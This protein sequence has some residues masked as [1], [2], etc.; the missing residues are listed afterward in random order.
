METHLVP[1]LTRPPK[2]N[3]HNTEHLKSSAE[4]TGPAKS[5]QSI[6]VPDTELKKSS[7]AYNKTT[8][9]KDFLLTSPGVKIPSYFKK[10]YAL[11]FRLCPK[12]QLYGTQAL[13]ATYPI[14]SSDIFPTNSSL[15][16]SAHTKS[17]SEASFLQC[18]IV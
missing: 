11:C 13:A 5:V 7:Y 3:L 12:P 8:E 10:S 18:S 14:C 1:P 4:D 17:L 2:L 16:S 6:N 9:H 15:S